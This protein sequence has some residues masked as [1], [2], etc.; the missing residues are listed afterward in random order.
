MTQMIRNA[1]LLGIGIALHI[2]TACFAEPLFSQEPWEQIVSLEAWRT[3]ATQET[4]LSTNLA[5]IGA[6]VQILRTAEPAN[7]HRCSNTHT[8]VFHRTDGSTITLGLLPGH[9]PGFHEYRLYKEGS[10]R[11]F[12]VERG[13]LLAVLGMLGIGMDTDG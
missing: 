8:I 7:D 12:R 11:V 9:T 6:L 2:I 3:D 13:Q 1:A 10:Y 4:V 5:T